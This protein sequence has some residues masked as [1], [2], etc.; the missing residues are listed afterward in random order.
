MLMPAI[1]IFFVTWVTKIIQDFIGGY[2]GGFT[3]KID[4]GWKW[5]FYQDLN[6]KKYLNILKR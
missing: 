4:G 3:W 5:E 1:N 6:L 2:I